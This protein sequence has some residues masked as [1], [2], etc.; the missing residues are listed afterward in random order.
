[1]RIL[2]GGSS[3]LIGSALVAYL[4]SAG[5]D[6]VRL[7]RWAAG[8]GDLEWSP[9]DGFLDP[10]S[11]VG[12]DAVVNLGGAGIGDKRWSAERKQL[13][14][15]S[16]IDATT[17]LA[18]TMAQLENPPSA[19]VSS[20]A[21]GFY[22]ERGDEELTEVSPAGPADDFLVQVTTAWEAATAPASAAGI[23]T[24]I[25]RH[26]IV[27]D[28]SGGA[29]GKM[30]LPYKLGVGGKLGNGRQW[31]SWISLYDEVRAL[32]HLVTGDLA[33]PV[34]LTAPNPVTNTELTKAL[35]SVLNRPTL[36]PTPR[37]GLELLLG[38]ELAKALVF[39]SAK[40]LPQKLLDSGF[41]F[42]HS[43][44]VDGLRAA[45]EGSTAAIGRTA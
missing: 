16:R 14:L 36:L 42:A 15:S 2:I 26:G 45:L 11:F 20:S 7:V 41:V 17:L 12:V 43:G 10:A 24:A 5:H 27:L 32:T 13:I 28:A 37:F 44:V 9:S 4:R 3:G 18:E 31:W 30:L 29:L 6:V 19:F 35:G 33:G 22:G 21:I 8:D 38:K 23:R 1:M 40:V 39:T 34:N 25:A